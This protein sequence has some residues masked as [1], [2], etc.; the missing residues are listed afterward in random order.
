[1]T[2]TVSISQLRN[3]MAEYLDKVT[4]G[5]QVLIRDEKKDIVVAELTQTKSFDKEAFGK[6]LK[7]AAGVFT[8]K[9]HPE[10]RTKKDVSKWLRETRKNAERNF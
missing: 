6:A 5:N 8:A 9:N 10:W 4:K 2:L 7:Q 3:N 1:M